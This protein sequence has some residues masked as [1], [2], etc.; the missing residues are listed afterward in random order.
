MPP[1]SPSWEDLLAGLHPS[2]LPEG[3]ALPLDLAEV[4]AQVRT[5]I[6]SEVSWAALLARAGAFKMLAR[7]WNITALRVADHQRSALRRFR[8][9]ASQAGW[10]QTLYAFSDRPRAVQVPLD[11]EPLWPVLVQIT[12]S[13]D[14]PNLFTSRLGEGLWCLY[15]HEKGYDLPYDRLHG[16]R[17]FSE[18]E[19]AAALKVT[20]ELLRSLW[21]ALRVRRTQGGRYAP[22]ADDW[23]SREWISAVARVLA[24]GGYPSWEEGCLFAALRELPGMP[25]VQ[26][27]TLRGAL[28][29][30]SHLR[31]TEQRG[32]WTW[33]G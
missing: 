17:F 4:Q 22:V 33:Q 12:R 6:T 7:E 19:A 18:Q 31:R 14:R 24:E 27:V 15:Q 16:D 21:P 13:Y 30:C 28:R 25:D 20:P 23:S 29:K 3:E 11:L 32:V 26:D 9:V 8:S 2:S 5:V 1:A 10:A